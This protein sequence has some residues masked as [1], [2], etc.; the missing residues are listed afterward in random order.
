MVNKYSHAFK[1]LICFELL[2]PVEKAR[3]F[4]LELEKKDSHPHNPYHYSSKSGEPIRRPHHH[5]AVCGTFDQWLKIKEVQSKNQPKNIYI[6]I[7]S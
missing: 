4:E 3:E 7:N 1:V 2:L 5:S 6:Y